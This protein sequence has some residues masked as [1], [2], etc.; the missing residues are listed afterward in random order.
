[1]EQL[2]DK[3]IEWGKDRNIIGGATPLSQQNK[4]EEEV[5]E[6]RSALETNNGPEIVDA[7]GD[8]LVVLTLQAAQL[9]LRLEDCLASAYDVIKDRKGKMH[10]GVFVK[11]ADFGK[12]GIS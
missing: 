11:E 10:N 9:G 1:M 7:I 3:V 6:L 12:Y 5:A 2:I 4:L 8:S